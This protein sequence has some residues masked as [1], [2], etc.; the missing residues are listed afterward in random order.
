MVTVGPFQVKIII[1]YPLVGPVF[2]T[3][4]IL[5][6]QVYSIFLK[7]SLKD[8]FEVLKKGLEILEIKE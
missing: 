8:S 4:T 3:G 7:L 1:F 5:D 2:R 6:C